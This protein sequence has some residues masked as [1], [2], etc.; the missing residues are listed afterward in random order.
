LYFSVW[1]Q[2]RLVYKNPKDRFILEDEEQSNAE[3]DET[4]AQIRRIQRLSPDHYVYHMQNPPN[5]FQIIPKIQLLRVSHHANAADFTRQSQMYRY[6]FGTSFF[7][8]S[9]S[10]KSR[11]SSHGH[12]KTAEAEAQLSSYHQIMHSSFYK[13]S[14]NRH[15][16]RT[17]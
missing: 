6:S 9:F 10:Q 2:S 4:C 7:I 5:H 12:H 13:Y 17:E 15:N 14:H 11:F 1:A 16:V 3:F 8:S